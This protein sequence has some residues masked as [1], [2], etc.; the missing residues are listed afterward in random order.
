[1]KQRPPPSSSREWPAYREKRAVRTPYP[2]S[3]ASITGSVTQKLVPP[4]KPVPPERPRQKS[5]SPRNIRGRKISPPGTVRGT[6]H[7]PPLLSMVPR[8]K[9]VFRPYLDC[10][11]SVL[12]FETLLAST[13]HRALLP[14]LL[15]G[16]RAL[17]PALRGCTFTH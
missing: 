11:R 2:T 13:G 14:A 17:L 10:R 15:T 8:P 16:H 7:G 4:P 9:S 6:A 3:L 5:W 12:Q 1:M